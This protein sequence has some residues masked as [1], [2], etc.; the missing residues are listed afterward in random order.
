MMGCHTYVGHRFRGNRSHSESYRYV[1]P[2]KPYVQVWV[3]LQRLFSHIRYNHESRSTPS[4]H[5]T[6]QRNRGTGTAKN[7]KIHSLRNR[8]AHRNSGN[9]QRAFVWSYAYDTPS[10]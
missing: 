10:I 5:Q 7:S 1:S 8:I 2:K 3:F 4:N 9:F 6:Y